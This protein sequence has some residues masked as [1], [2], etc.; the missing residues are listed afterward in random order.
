[1][2]LALQT[3]LNE[4]VAS[5]YPA[6]LAG[7]TVLEKDSNIYITIT[8][9]KPNLRSY[10][11]GKWNS[12]WVVSVDTSSISGEIKVHAHYFED[13]NFQLQ[14]SKKIASE[15][16][17]TSSDSAFAASVATVIKVSTFIFSMPTS[18]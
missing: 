13:G 15:S 5:A 18:S 8:G 7:C 10:W 3:K 17:D 2:R 1:L 4:Y 9:E 14:T 11:S 16:I 12:N 6:E